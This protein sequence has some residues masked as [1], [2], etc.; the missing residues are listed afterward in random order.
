MNLLSTSETAQLQLLF[1]PRPMVRWGIRTNCIAH[2]SFI[3]IQLVWRLIT[4]M[5]GCGQTLDPGTSLEI[6]ILITAPCLLSSFW[7]IYD[8]RL[9][10]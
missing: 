8:A 9:A 2:L 3:T 5:A 1:R 7:P 10:G 4:L 6:P